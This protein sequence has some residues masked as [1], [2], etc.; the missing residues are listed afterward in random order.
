[1]RSFGAFRMCLIPEIPASDRQLFKAKK[2]FN[3]NA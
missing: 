3:P 1:M 2:Y